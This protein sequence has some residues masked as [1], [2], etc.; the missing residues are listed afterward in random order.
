MWD[1]YIYLNLEFLYILFNGLMFNGDI[2]LNQ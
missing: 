1:K 2:V